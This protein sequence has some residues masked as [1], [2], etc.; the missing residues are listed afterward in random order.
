[1]K[2]IEEISSEIAVL[3]KQRFEMAVKLGEPMAFEWIE[4][5]FKFPGI[6]TVQWRQYTPYFNDGDPCEFAIHDIYI[7]LGIDSEEWNDDLWSE[8]DLR[9]TLQFDS[10]E[11]KPSY[12]SVAQWAEYIAQKESQKAWLTNLGWTT[13]LV[14]AWAVA[15]SGALE[16]LCENEKFLYDAF[17]DH[18]KVVYGPDGTCHTDDIDHD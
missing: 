3:E 18:C 14:I 17:G 9:W 12:K 1:M 13:E 5:L 6:K 11:E 7:S 15:H 8:W 2:T 10:D 16:K 4:P